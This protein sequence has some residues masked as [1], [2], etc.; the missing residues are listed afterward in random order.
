MMMNTSVLQN[1]SEQHIVPVSILGIEI[2]MIVDSGASVNVLDSLAFQRFLKTN[3]RVYP[4]GSLSPITVQ[5]TFDVSSG[6]TV[7]LPL[8]R[9]IVVENT[10]AG[11]LLRK[12]MSITLSLLRVGPVEPDVVHSVAYSS[13]ATHATLPSLR[14][15]Q[16]ATQYLSLFKGVSRK[17][18][19]S[20]FTLT[21][22]LHQ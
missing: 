11:E 22:T 2:P 3:L 4:F 14:V 19:M 21:Q 10:N 7:C 16:L 6:A 1:S 12:F 20:R 8:A 18:T 13:P 5:G 9:F 15:E 17:T